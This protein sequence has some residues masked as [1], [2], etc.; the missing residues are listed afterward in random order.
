MERIRDEAWKEQD[1]RQRIRIKMAEHIRTNEPKISDSDVKSL[2]KAAELGAADGVA[3][4]DVTSYA[5][6][7]A[8]HSRSLAYSAL[9]FALLILLIVTEDPFTELAELTNG[10]RFLHDDLDREIVDQV[11][12]RPKKQSAPMYLNVSCLSCELCVNDSPLLLQG[13]APKRSKSSSQP[14]APSPFFGSR[15]SYFSAALKQGDARM[16]AM[17]TEVDGAEKDVQYGFAQQQRLE[18]SNRVRVHSR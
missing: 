7:W 13:G 15:L 14:A 1:K 17:N 8:L 12:P 5:G 10:M 11:V 2:L 3:A 4:N 18:R 16:N 6:L 9:Q